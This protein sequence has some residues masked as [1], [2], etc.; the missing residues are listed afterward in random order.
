MYK[1]EVVNMQILLAAHLDRLDLLC[2]MQTRPVRLGKIRKVVLDGF[3]RRPG[4]IV[5]IMTLS[6]SSPQKVKKVLLKFGGG[7][8]GQL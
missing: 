5:R 8:G 2:K 3:P 7:S 4:K 6:S 1:K